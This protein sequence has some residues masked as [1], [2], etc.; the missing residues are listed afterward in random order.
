MAQFNPRQH[1][2]PSWLTA[3][4]TG[5]VVPEP[6]SRSSVPWES[7]TA[8]GAGRS[9]FLVAR[10]DLIRSVSR[11]A[12]VAR[13]ACYPAFRGRLPGRRMRP[14]AAT[15]SQGGCHGGAWERSWRGSS[16]SVSLVRAGT[17]V[18]ARF[19]AGTIIAEELA[20]RHDVPGTTVADSIRAFGSRLVSAGT[21]ASG[22]RYRQLPTLATVS[23]H[24]IGASTPPDPA[25]G[26]ATVCPGS[27]A[28]RQF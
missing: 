12:T 17:G 1:R 21:A 8:T 24:L 16:P 5:W 11:A 18:V 7:A 13:G 14:W 2:E 27:G 19:A 28:R 10:P 4:I 23:R 9:M 6:V 25:C 20:E 22:H 26:H 3:W 15:C